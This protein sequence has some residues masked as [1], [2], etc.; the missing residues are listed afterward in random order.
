MQNCL[1]IYIESNLLK[2]AKISKDKSEYKVE[3]Y[4]IKFYDNLNEA[5]KKVIEE[6]YS[7][8]TP[9]SINLMNERYMYYDIF[10][11]LNKNDIQNTVQT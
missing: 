5:I 4:G 9:I 11:L 8:S 10:S 3:N 1:G 7:Y 6:T 2:Y